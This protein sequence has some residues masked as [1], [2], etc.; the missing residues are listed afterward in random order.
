MWTMSGSPSPP[1]VEPLLLG[2]A[3]ALVAWV[4]LAAVLFAT[5]GKH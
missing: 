1:G 2:A 3:A 4:I 5:Y